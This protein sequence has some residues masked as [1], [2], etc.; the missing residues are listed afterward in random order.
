MSDLAN[1]VIVSVGS[2][3]AKRERERQRRVIRAK[4]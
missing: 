2:T 4:R 1:I 3:S